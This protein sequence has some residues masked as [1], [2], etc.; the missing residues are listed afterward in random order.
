MTMTSEPSA[1]RG[2]G[3][4]GPVAAATSLETILMLIGGTWLVIGLFV[5]GYAHTE[6]IDTETEDFF[7]P[8]HALFY[9]GFVFTTVVVAR[10]AHR[11]A[12]PTITWASLP[13]GYGVAAAGLIIFAIGGVGDGIWHTVFGVESGLDALLSPTHLLLFVGLVSILTA[14]ARARWLDPSPCDGWRDLGPVVASAAITTALVAF[15]FVYVFGLFNFWLQEVPYDPAATFDG[16][17]VNERLVQLGLARAYMA[18]AI[19]L[20]PTLL[21]IRRWRPPPGSIA[22][23]WTTPVLLSALGFDGDLPAVPATVIGGLAFEF[24]FRV[25]TKRLNEQTAIRVTAAVGT[26]LLWSIWMAFN[27][28]SGAEVA[29]PVELWSGQIGMSAIFAYGLAFLA[30][31]RVPSNRPL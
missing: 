11:R 22:V 8:W 1:E 30:T 5:D 17:V 27:H 9:S 25:S 20:A 16:D 23:I 24:I 31:P 21:L 12:D 10:I 29:W 3:T 6:I 4:A 7:T 2:G 14:P 13:P 19:L 18:T 26:A 15:F 28:L